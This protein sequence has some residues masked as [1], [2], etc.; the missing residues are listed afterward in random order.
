MNL[1]TLNASVEKVQVRGYVYSYEFSR[2]VHQ[3]GDESDQALEFEEEEWR[4]W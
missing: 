4:D 2:G 3:P 1:F